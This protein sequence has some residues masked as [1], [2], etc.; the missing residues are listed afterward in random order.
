MAIAFV[1]DDVA[2]FPNT[3]ADGGTLAYGSNVSAGSLLIAA[4][5]IQSATVQGNALTDTLGNTWTMLVRSATSRGFITEIW[6]APCPS[7]GANTVTFDLTGTANCFP[8]LQEYSGFSNGVT[9]GVTNSTNNGTNTTTHSAGDVTTTVADSLILTVYAFDSAF[10][11]NG[12]LTDWVGLTPTIRSD[13]QYKIAS[14][15]E[16]TDGEITTAEVARGPAAIASFS[17]TAGGGGGGTILPQ[18]M[19]QYYS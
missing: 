5:A 8:N 6:Y 1:Q 2:A 10:V 13:Y 19:A 4:L 17:E 15:T 14:A 3:V 16:T 18:I 12:R 9:A 7:G 11:V